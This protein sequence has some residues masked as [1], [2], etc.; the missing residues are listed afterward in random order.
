M[1]VDSGAS[2]H[3]VDDKLDKDIKQ[4]MFD[5]QEFDTPRTITTAGLHTPLGTATGKLR[6]KVTGSNGR[7]RMATLPITNVPGIGRNLFS[8]GAAQ[9]EGITT[10]ISDNALLEKGNIDFP[11]RRDGQ[12]F[13]GPGAFAIYTDSISFHCNEQS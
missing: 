6:S 10:I 2:D 12:L 7:T 9:G 8:S 13:I 11:L 1:V 4:L 5:Y 3:Y